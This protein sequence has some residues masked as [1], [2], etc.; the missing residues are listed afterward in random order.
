MNNSEIARD[1]QEELDGFVSYEDESDDDSE[2]MEGEERDF[3]E[4][5]DGDWDSGMASAGHGNDE[6]YE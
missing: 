2:E 4:S 5:M 3:D 6:D 1:L